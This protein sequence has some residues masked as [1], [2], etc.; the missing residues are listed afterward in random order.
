MCSLLEKEVEAAFHDQLLEQAAET[1]GLTPGRFK[2]LGGFENYVYEGE[3]NGVPVIV[4]FTHSSHR[5]EEQVAAEMD[6]IDYL[7][8]QGIVIPGYSHT[9]Q[10]SRTARLISGETYF[11]ATVFAKAGG[12]A[13]KVDNERIWNKAMFREWGRVTAQMHRETRHYHKQEGARRPEWSDDELLVNAANYIK[14]G[15][16]YVADQ[17]EAVLLQLAA[18]PKSTDDYGLIH[19]DIHYGN[20][21]VEDGKLHVFDFDDC[22]YMWFV[23]DLAIPLY[24]AMSDKIPAVYEGNLNAYAADFF[25]SFW[26]GYNEEYKLSL[27]WLALIPLFLKFRDITLYLVINQK[28]EQPD[29][30]TANWLA[31]IKDRIKRDIPIVELDYRALAHEASK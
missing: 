28:L 7:L 10:G 8:K 25:Q 16:S 27:E 26:Q 15:D 9:R 20:F 4:R 5:T 21:F 19:T 24:Y 30:D 2:S 14:P 6:W 22:G 3:K 12:S 1:F 11:T 18:L 17:L 13:V 31:V 29:E 23:H